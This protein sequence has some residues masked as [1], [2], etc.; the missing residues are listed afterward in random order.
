[1]AELKLDLKSIDEIKKA[2]AYYKTLADVSLAF[3][4]ERGR[5]LL[6]EKSF[7]QESISRMCSKYRDMQYALE[8]VMPSLIGDNQTERAILTM[9]AAE[10]QDTS[11]KK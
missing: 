2:H 11:D 1:M 3:L 4:R 10:N 5:T 8:F 9:L 7:A 6:D